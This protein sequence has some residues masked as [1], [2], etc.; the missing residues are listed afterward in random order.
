[1][2]LMRTRFPLLPGSLTW[3]RCIPAALQ[4]R[5]NHAAGV[6]IWCLCPS[7]LLLYL[8]YVHLKFCLKFF[9]VSTLLILE[10]ILMH[11]FCIIYLL[12]M[13]LNHKITLSFPES[14][15]LSLLKLTKKQT[16]KQKNMP[17]SKIST[18]LYFVFYYIM[19]ILS[20]HSRHTLIQALC[21]LNDPAVITITLRDWSSSFSIRPLYC[22][23]MV[24]TVTSMSK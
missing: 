9:N 4:S 24:V 8:S 2:R 23:S 20:L 10:K 15:Y 12:N 5:Y 3:R 18:N 6:C 11:C 14:I 17:T 7:S 16:N 1:M 13:I 21:V 19:S 22:V